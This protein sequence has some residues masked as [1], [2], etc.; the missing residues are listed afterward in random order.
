MKQFLLF[1]QF[2]LSL[3]DAFPGL[4]DGSEIDG[5][6]LIEYLAHELH[7]LNIAS[8]LEKSQKETKG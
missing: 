1:R 7:R 2:L 4:I 6:D 3:I 8:E 5:A